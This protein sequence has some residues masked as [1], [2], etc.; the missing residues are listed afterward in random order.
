ML[1]GATQL[2]EDE[3]LPTV[4]VTLVGAPETVIG[5]TEAEGVEAALTPAPLVAVTA[6]V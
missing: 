6:N 1:A 2:T 5:V 4:A 3:P